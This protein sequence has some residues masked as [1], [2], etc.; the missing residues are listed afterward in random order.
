MCCGHPEE[1]QYCCKLTIIKESFV[2]NEVF[3]AWI[4]LKETEFNIH[5]Q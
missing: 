4:I 3:I 1:V 2:A 5:N